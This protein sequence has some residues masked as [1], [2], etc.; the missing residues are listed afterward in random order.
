MVSIPLLMV[1]RLPYK[2]ACCRAYI[3][4]LGGSLAT[5]VLTTGSAALLLDGNFDILRLAT[6]TARLAAG[7]DL[8]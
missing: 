6:L 1:S 2:S 4:N 7:L 5:L 3:D 8:A